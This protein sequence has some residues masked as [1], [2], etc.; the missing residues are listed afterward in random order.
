MDAQEVASLFGTIQLVDEITLPLMGVIDVVREL[1]T[2]LM[3]AAAALAGLESGGAGIRVQGTGGADQGLIP[4][5]SPAQ[6]V[7]HASGERG[8]NGGRVVVNLT[9]YGSSPHELASMVQRAVRERG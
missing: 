4:A 8:G 5:G 3:G 1:E 9:A 2:A 7:P 6:P